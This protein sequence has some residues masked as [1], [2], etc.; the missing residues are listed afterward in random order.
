MN[1]MKQIR[2]EKVT[3]NAGVGKPGPEM[4]KAVKLLQMISGK[5][6]VET[7]TKKRIPTW[8]IRP[9]LSIGAKVTIRG[10][11]AEELLQR[12]LQSIDLKMKPWKVDREG[13]FAFGIKEYIDIPGVK[14]N[15]EIGITG[16]EVAVTM[17]RPGFRIKKRRIMQRRVP[18]R[19]RI[20]KEET[21]SF[22]KEKF[23]VK[24]EED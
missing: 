15:M 10:K 12:L 14:Y 21:M 17:I 18:K 5:K 16:L 20:T 1:P 24:F 6:P 11:Q 4:E 19:H 2:I 8:G 22:L 13:N 9:G 3:L 7:K 23:G